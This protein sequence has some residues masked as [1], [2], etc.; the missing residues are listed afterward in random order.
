MKIQGLVSKGLMLLLI[1]ALVFITA[2]GSN[3][4]KN[5][6]NNEPA[7]AVV[8]DKKDA[9]PAAPTT[10]PKKLSIM[11]WGPDARHEATLKALDVYTAQ[12]PNVTFT[13]EYLAW[14]G[15]WAK[16]PTL[17]ASKT[18]TDILQMDAAFIN[19]YVSRGTLEDLSDID[20]TGVVDPQIIEK[21]KIDGKLYGIPLSHNGQG[22]AYNKTALEAAGVTL[23][24]EGWT[25]DDYFAFAREAR[26]KLPKD[27][28]PIGFTGSWDGYQY[29]QTANGKG[30]M[31]QDGGKT[32]NLDKD[33]FM[34]FYNEHVALIKEGAIPPAE[35]AAA[36]IEND[37]QA[38]PMGS[39]KV[40]TSSKSVGSVSATEALLP[41][42]ID[43]VNMPV[44]SAGGGW[45]QSTIFLSISTDSKNKEEAK[46]FVKWFITDPEAGKVLGMTRGIPINNEVF[47]TLE[48][49]LEQKDIISKK[50][51][52]AA[53]PYALPFYGAP[54]GYSEFIDFFKNEMDAVMFGQQSVEKAYDHINKKG[55]DTAAS[56]K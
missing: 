46:K 9:E 25:W 20:L 51:A 2:C 8:D 12:N 43:V 47:K 38:D 45:A 48:P 24:K 56:I 36:F 21:L 52:D 3:N 35:M 6:A 31:M 55:M 19:E 32:F 4:T 26:S 41:G 28:Y 49:N 18:M 22:I 23:P 42:Q 30:P 17:A 44:G 11:W 1:A 33:L 39:G 53:A 14:D 50:L 37:A 5:A 27:Q 16:L 54:A 15:F 10:E 7:P 40:M 13:P 34:K 29:Y